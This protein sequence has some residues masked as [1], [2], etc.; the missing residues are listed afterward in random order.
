MIENIT[1]VTSLTSEPDVGLKKRREG[2]GPFRRKR[3]VPRPAREKPR[4][5]ALSARRSRIESYELTKELAVI[6]DLVRARAETGKKFK[7]AFKLNSE[8]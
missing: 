1:R 6:A 7:A 8:E 2:S 3:Q 4:L 5:S